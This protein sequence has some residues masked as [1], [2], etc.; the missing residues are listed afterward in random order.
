MHTG[1]SAAVVIGPLVILA[2]SVG[3]QGIEGKNP[4]QPSL[5]ARSAPTIT[6]R[7]LRFKDLNQNGYLDPYEDWRLSAEERA[8]DLISRM[9]LE[10]KAGVMM[11]GTAPSAADTSGVGRGARYD[12]E[13]ASEMIGGMKV[14][15]FIT[16]LGGDPQLLAEENNKLQEIA[17]RTRLGIPVT[18]S[19]DPR[20][21]F[22][23]IVGASVSAGAFSTWPETLGFAAIG[24]PELMRR[25]ADIA[26]QEYRAVGIQ[27]AL[28]PQADLATEPR[29]PR[30]SGTFGSEPQLAKKMVEAYVAGFQDGED[31]IKSSSV[32]AVA[33][34][35]VGYGAAEEGWDSHNAYGKYARFTS[36]H[37]ALHLVP[38]EGAFAAHVAGIMPTYSV[39]KGVEIDGK[40]LE[41]VGA[42]YNK[43][44]LSDMLRARYRFDGVVLTD[45]LITNDCDGECLE[46]EKPGVKPMI[47]EGHFGMPWGVE[48]MSKVDRYAKAVNV[49]VDQFGGV[50][51]SDLL[52]AAVEQGKIAQPRIDESVA[53]ILKQKFS[54]GLFEDPYVDPAEATRIVGNKDFQD[55]ALKAQERS[56]VLLENKGGLIP[57]HP[58]GLKVY[59]YGIDPRA[60][61]AAGFTTVDILKDADFA[62]I[63]TSTPYEQ[64]HANYFFG[65]RHQ[66]GS[67]A[68]VDG[69]PDYEAIKA[70]ADAKVPTILTVYLARPAIL[71]NVKD[72]VDVLIGNFGVSDAALFAVL[73]G[74]AKPEGRLPFELPSSMAEVL[75]Q[76]PDLPDDTA[77]PLYPFGAG[78]SD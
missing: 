12:L 16:R 63:R 77:N 36:D 62:L 13:R 70:A 24:D 41:Q 23:Y 68:F 56:L 59:V 7:G 69:N 42:G 53:R 40:P 44:L 50:T 61:K 1:C 54:Q 6:L 28:S 49:G 65:S 19:T 43:Q 17:E 26:R 55:A 57:M 47:R 14:N 5:E 25:F 21:H 31:G 37:F 30:I 58:K 39:L 3:A 75:M 73:T 72:K 8:R 4:T 52:V 15:T 46:G 45:W 78:L 20:N 64:P 66:E 35:W 18:I 9:T 34:H 51:S 11:H 71:T 29:W 10:E 2:S 67:L 33:K 48:T 38:F 22:Q 74:Q 32:I 27:E 76:A 60:A